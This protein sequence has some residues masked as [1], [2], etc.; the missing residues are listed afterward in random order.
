MSISK[1]VDPT[2]CMQ[3]ITGVA[4]IYISYLVV[5][6]V[7]ESMLKKTYTNDVTGAE[8]KF[9]WAAGFLIFPC[10]ICWIIGEIV[11]HYQIKP[12]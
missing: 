10:G 6:I 8:E 5:G 3:L 1:Y 11:N 2:R 12:E 7:Q 9:Q 4:G